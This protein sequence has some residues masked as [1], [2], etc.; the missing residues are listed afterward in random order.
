MRTFSNV[1]CLIRMNRWTLAFL[2]LVFFG[3]ILTVHTLMAKTPQQPYN[4]IC[5][6]G[7]LE[8]RYYPE[9]V[10]ATVKNQDTTY[11]GSSSKNFRVLAGYIFGG[12]EK[13]QN[14][15]MTAPVHMAHDTAGSSMSFVMPQGYALDNLPAPVGSGIDLHQ[16][17][18]EYVAV[19]RFGGYASDKRIAEKQNE[20]NL[21]LKKAGVDHMNN[22][23]FL[24]YNAPWDFLFRRNEI[25]VGISA[26]AVANMKK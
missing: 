2:A 7:D 17:P 19:I 3:T 25:I 22:F 10:M 23:R 8:F 15:A 18:A 24:G 4:E 13:K 21:L 12:N 14:I 11:R 1:G 6:K 9:A 26:E 16:V 5:T 20:L